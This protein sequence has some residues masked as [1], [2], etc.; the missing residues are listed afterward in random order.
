[1]EFLPGLWNIPGS[2]LLLSRVGIRRFVPMRAR[3][4]K[5][6]KGLRRAV[7]EHKIFHL[8]CHPCNLTVDRAAMLRALEDILREAARLRAA[9]QLTITTMGA[10][11]DDLAS[12]Q[13]A[14]VIAH[15]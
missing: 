15:S 6:R 3:A 8:W 13:E 7:R 10:L 14:A 11:A 12:R 9:G 4:R 5:A 1:L 2:M